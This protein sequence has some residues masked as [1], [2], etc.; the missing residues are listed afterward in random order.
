MT[1]VVLDAGA[2]IALE[3][4]D[5]RVLALLQ[6]LI[7]GRV[8]AHVPATVVGQAWRGSPRQHGVTRLLKAEAVRVHPFSEQVAYRVGVLLASTRTADVVDAH[9]A[10]LARSLAAPVLTSD[11]ADLERL[12]PSLTLFP[13]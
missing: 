2:L 8:A 11:P 10:L 5:R 12:D 9:V 1:T 3:R 7:R 4:G 6:E 13:V